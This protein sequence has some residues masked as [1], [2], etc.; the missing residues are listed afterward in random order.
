MSS[1]ESSELLEYAIL[2]LR[3]RGDFAREKVYA[4]RAAQR[5]QGEAR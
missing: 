5:R 2:R 1:A 3:R 4:K